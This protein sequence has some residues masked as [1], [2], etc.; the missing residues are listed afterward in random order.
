MA[1]RLKTFLLGQVEYIIWEDKAGK[2]ASL[3]LDSNIGDNAGK[4]TFTGIPELAE[5]ALLLI[6]EIERLRCMIDDSSVYANCGHDWADCGIDSI[7]TERLSALLS[8]NLA[9][10]GLGSNSQGIEDD[11]GA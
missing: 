1:T 6:N 7:D 11:N 5:G 10:V 4:L 9:D 8:K 2:P 3:T